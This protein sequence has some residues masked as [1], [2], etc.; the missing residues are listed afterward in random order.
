M[1]FGLETAI[2]TVWG[3][4]TTTFPTYTLPGTSGSDYCVFTN[5]MPIDL[6][7]GSFGF[8]ISGVDGL[9]TAFQVSGPLQSA[10]A[11]PT[12]GPVAGTLLA[13]LL[14]G[15]TALV[16]RRRELPIVR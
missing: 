14:V 13:S 7:E 10:A 12:V 1:G 2:G 9:I 3:F 6:G 4:C 5:V 11:V 15:T 16:L 8:R